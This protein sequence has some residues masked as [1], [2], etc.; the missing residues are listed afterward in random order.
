MRKE[1]FASA[2]TTAVSIVTAGAA[3]AVPGS[4]MS[5]SS[6]SATSPV[7]TPS[8]GSGITGGGDGGGRGAC[9]FGGRIGPKGAWMNSA[10]PQAG[11]GKWVQS[12]S[13][14][15]CRYSNDG[16]TTNWVKLSYSGKA[17]WYFFDNEGWM[18]TG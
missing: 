8:V 4:S 11:A 16:Y 1:I 10:A 9:S 3:V 5:V 17:D 7:A 13:H 14:W 12:G 2:P 15:W 6:T 18:Q